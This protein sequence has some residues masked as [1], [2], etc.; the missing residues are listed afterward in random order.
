MARKEKSAK[1]AAK[2]AKSV[3]II[4]KQEKGGSPVI[5]DP[6]IIAVRT[7]K[8]RLGI[9]AGNRLVVCDADIPKYREKR[10]RFEKY[11][12]WY[13]FLAFI[14]L[15]SFIFLSPTLLGFAYLVGGVLLIMSFSLLTYFPSIREEKG[16]PAK[17]A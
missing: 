9:A 11:L 3:C 12:M 2:S 4:C 5:D 13:G 6:Y 15:V 1:P 14:L 10:K 7:L 16:E 8:T 17:K